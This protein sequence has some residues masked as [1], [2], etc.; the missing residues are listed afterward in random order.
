MYSGYAPLS[1]RLAQFLSR[2]QG[3][4]GLEEVLRLL[5]GPTIEERQTLPPGLQK[6][7][8]LVAIKT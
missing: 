1:V 8:F 4:R 7:K 3:W 5:P 6:R 2:P